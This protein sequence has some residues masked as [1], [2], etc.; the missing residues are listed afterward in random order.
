[1][2]IPGTPEECVG[3][4]LDRMTKRGWRGDKGEDFLSSPSIILVLG[5]FFSFGLFLFLERV[6]TPR[7]SSLWVICDNESAVV[8]TKG[9]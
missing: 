8:C 9:K 5:S 2:F 7:A 4:N 3:R 1:M 6:F